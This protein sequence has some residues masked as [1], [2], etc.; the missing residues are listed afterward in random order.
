MESMVDESGHEIDGYRVISHNPLLTICR[1]NCLRDANKVCRA[2]NNDNETNIFKAIKNW[3]T[4][5]SESNI[6][7]RNNSRP[8]SYREVDVCGQKNGVLRDD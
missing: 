1:C 3:W 6:D 8:H 2:V 4:R 7:A 5:D